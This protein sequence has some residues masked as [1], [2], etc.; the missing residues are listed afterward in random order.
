MNKFLITLNS[1]LAIAVIVLFVLVFSDKNSGKAENTEIKTETNV[2]DKEN[3]IAFINLDTLV[4]SYQ[5]SLDLQKDLQKK[6]NTI[7]SDI[8]KKARALENDAT[9][10][11]NRMKKGTITSF[12]ANDVRNSLIQRDQDLQV[13]TAQKQREMAEEEQVMVNKIMDDI[14]TCV[15]KYQQEFNYSLILTTSAA[16]NT[17]MAY[18]N[19]LDITSNILERLNSQYAKK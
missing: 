9:D 1:V 2:S 11:E 12:E 17:V 5:R 4:S 3:K 19:S 15:E 8:E 13:Y 16:T 10:L 6:V 18:D 14:K 7:Q